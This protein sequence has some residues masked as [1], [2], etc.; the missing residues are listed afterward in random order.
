MNGP[1]INPNSIAQPDLVCLADVKF[2]M[3]L[4]KLSLFLQFS[5]EPKIV[6]VQKSHIV[7]ASQA[8]AEIARRRNAL[9]WRRKKSQP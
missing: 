8:Y 6:R 3:L 7:T 5:A 1:R 9:S 2:R 4:H